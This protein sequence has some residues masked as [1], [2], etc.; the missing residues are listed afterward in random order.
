MIKIERFINELMSSNCFV[1]W[2]DETHRC[3]IIDPA[4]EKALKELS[5]IESHSLVL[6]YILLTH[7]HTDHTWG[8]NALLDAHKNSKV[9]CSEKC[10]LGLPEAGTTYFR[11]YYDDPNYSYIVKRVDFVAEDI[12]F[13]LKW[14]GTTIQ[15][16]LTP[17]HS[18]GSMCIRLNDTLFSGDTIM[19]SKPFINKRNGSFELYKKSISEIIKVLPQDLLVYPGHGEIFP[20]STFEYK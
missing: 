20:L 19:Q 8:V 12:D 4:S 13:K 2:D 1:V 5:F 11:F 7:E 3:V 10:K 9:V 18:F 17:G 16:Y 15:F 6:D 14:N